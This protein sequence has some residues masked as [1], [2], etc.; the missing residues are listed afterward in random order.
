MAEGP[1]G[2]TPRGEGT[3]SGQRGA[4]GAR[5]HGADRFVFK[6]FAGDTLGHAFLACFDV[7]ALTDVM[8]CMQNVHSPD[9]WDN[10]DNVNSWSSVLELD[11]D[12]EWLADQLR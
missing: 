9:L 6:E 11:L 12:K 7:L 4:C 2:A 8:T 1:H 3:R 5:V 10:D